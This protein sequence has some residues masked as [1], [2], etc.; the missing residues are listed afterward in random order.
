[1]QSTTSNFQNSSADLV[2]FARRYGPAKVAYDGAE[3][4]ALSGDAGFRRYYRLSSKPNLMVVDSPPEQGRNLEYVRVN[5]FLASCAIPVPH[6]HA[7]SF[8]KGVFVIEDLGNRLLQDA[9]TRETAK[10]LY[11]QALETLLKIQSIGYRPVWIEPYSGEKLLEEMERFSEWFV[12]KLLG[13]AIHSDIHSMIEQAFSVLLENA[14]EQPQVF[15]HR[16]FHC[17]NLMLSDSRGSGPDADIV[18]IDF[19]DAVWGPITYDLVSLCRDC[20]IRWNHQKTDEILAAYGEN[21]V[22]AGLITKAQTRLLPR[23]ADL[24]GLQRHI[25]VLGVF[26]RL[27]VRDGKSNYLDD[28]PLVLRY[29]LEILDRYSDRYPEFSELNAWLLEQLVPVIEKQS[30]YKSWRDAGDQLEF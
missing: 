20:Y 9:L 2:E 11:E 26:S 10:A 30:W 22:C 5:D 17:R 19:Q 23:W 1:M 27:S 13:V 14:T 25:K 21:L 28:L 29:T 12:Q 16:D 8:A 15:V 4:S 6:I 3:L 18:V 24:M 7:V